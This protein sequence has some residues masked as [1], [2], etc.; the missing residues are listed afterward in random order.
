MWDAAIE[1]SPV[2]YRGDG[3]VAAISCSGQ[4]VWRP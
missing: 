1:R 4:V 2:F 3:S